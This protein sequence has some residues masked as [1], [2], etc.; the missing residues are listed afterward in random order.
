MVLCPHTAR[1]ADPDRSVETADATR[2]PVW[3]GSCTLATLS[4]GSSPETRPIVTY[5]ARCF[6]TVHCR[7]WVR[8]FQ[9]SMPL[10]HATTEQKNAAERTGSRWPD[11]AA[12]VVHGSVR[13]RCSL[14]VLPVR[15]L[16]FSVMRLRSSSSYPRRATFST[17]A[18][19]FRATN[20]LG[21]PTVRF[22]GGEG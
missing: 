15:P 1:T 19:I 4:L 17:L 10:G 21:T 6:L 5:R 8:A 13:A 16:I 11:P 14:V 7:E 20:P 12:L 22:A 9:L 18:A 3:S 2:R